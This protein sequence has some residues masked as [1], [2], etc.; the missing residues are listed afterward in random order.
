M[1][2][3]GVKVFDD[4]TALDFIY[5]L[6]ETKSIVKKMTKHFKKVIKAKYL[7]HDDAQ[8]VLVSAVIIDTAINGNTYFES[9]D[10][11]L[12]WVLSLNKKDFEKLKN[13]AVQAITRVLSDKSELKELWEENDEQYNLWK[14]DKLDIQKRLM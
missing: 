7:E 10:E 14:N 5:E 4:D 13:M 8:Y 3:W 9:N 12:P 6:K 1:G 2:A 11:F